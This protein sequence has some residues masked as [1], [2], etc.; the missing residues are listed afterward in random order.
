MK[1][2]RE[3]A[4]PFKKST[5]LFTIVGGAVL[6]NP[7]F[8]ADNAST[9]A[10]DNGD[11]EEIVITGIKA[12][13]KASMETK[14]DAVGVVDAINS[15]DIGK[16]PDTNLSEALQRVTGI[17]IDRRNG[18]GA[19]VTARGFGPQYNM[20]TLNGRE[21]PGA[22]GFGSG[23]FITGGQGNGSRSFNFAN[24]AAESISAVE[25]YKTSRADISPGGM[26]ATINIKTA[27]PF[28]NNGIVAN[29]GVKALHD[30]TRN[31]AGHSVTPE[32]SGIFSYTDDAKVWGIGLTGSYSKRDSGTNE[33]TVNDWHIQAWDGSAPTGGA[34]V[35]SVNQ[36]AGPFAPNAVVTN[37]PHD[38]QLYGIPNDI[39]YAFS[40]LTR[41]RTN[42][43]L[44]VQVAP[45]EG[46]T[47]T[48]D[49]TY[50]N[51]KLTED[52]SEQTEWM[53][54]NGFTAVT[55]D[56]NEAVATPV[57]LDEL[58]GSGKD[59]GYEQQH[60]QQKNTLG[61][62][63]FNAEWKVNDTFKIGF[64]YND[65]TAKSL[66]DDPLTGM[67]QLAVSVAG[68][69]PSSCL[70]FDNST[71]PKCTDQSNFWRQTFEFNN[72]LPIAMRTL[73]P[74][75]TA[76]VANTGGNSAYVFDG[77][78]LGTQVLRSSYTGQTTDVKQARLDGE[79]NFSDKGKFQFGVESK[80]VEMH[81]QN[82]GGYMALGDWG[83][84]DV[85][86]VPGMVALLKT[87][88]IAGNFNKYSAPGAPTVAYYGNADQLG[89]WAIT[90][91]AQGGGGYGVWAEGAPANGTL[92]FN[93]NFS[94]DA[95]VKETSSS[96]Y[97]QF[98]MQG[99]LGGL[100]ASVVAG[101]RYEKTNVNSTTLQ[102]VPT[103]LL[104][105]DDND[106]SI[107]RS[108]N[109]T[110]V[111]GDGHYNNLLPN[112]NFDLHFSDQ[113]IGRFAYSKTI[114]R[115]NYGNLEAGATVNGPGGSTLNGF[116]ATA[117]QN[118]PGLLPL[119]SDNFDLSLE[120]YFSD[121]GYI[122]AG[123]F[124]KRVNNF[125]GTA[126]FDQSLFG[127]QDQTGGPEAQKVFNW[128]KANNFATD[129]S[130]LFTAMAMDMNPGT[131]TD[132]NG[133]WTG[134]L[135]NYN[136][137]NAQHIA[138]ATKYDAVPTNVASYVSGSSTVT[139]TS[140]SGAGTDPNYIFAVQTPVNNK[141][142]RIHGFELG[143]QMFFGETG[144]GLQANYTIVRGDVHFDDT[145]DPNVNQFAL[146]GLSD[147]ANVVAMYE[148]YGLNARLA[149]NWRDRYLVNVNQ[150]GFRNPVYADP[151]KQIDLSVGYDF[152]KHFSVSF[153]GINLTGEGVRYYG[154]S[155]KQLWRLE[156]SGPRYELGVRYKL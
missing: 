120:Y 95:R 80:S 4:L 60:N 53:Q 12:S 108:A 10:S 93:P 77:T 84:G 115:A 146:L 153:D 75:Q 11:L 25:V 13:L 66:P 81:Q 76:A 86:Q 129:D 54:R 34:T 49:Y 143:G 87:Y 98:T 44:T 5:Y 64:D 118:D 48:A 117:N 99:E 119:E 35:N 140:V 6:L 83:V 122:S 133:T 155:E 68:K 135:A 131:F 17:S 23:D 73:Y 92:R 62:F 121:T 94:T 136:G 18:E 28:D 14:K 141:A 45:V 19:T 65:A 27:R 15:E 57:F 105:K 47:L 149:W 1:T 55:F 156:S 137:T 29:I 78:S 150:G 132:A 20:V 154:R 82:S 69:V 42:A 24:L 37:A 97:F 71:P 107:N 103:S 43:Q 85:G 130:S 148:K 50:A 116:Q 111:T 51:S 151:H 134:G 110:P 56:T 63:G 46:L 7:A 38:G 147:S 144:F 30:S 31:V 127:I 128:L 125:I 114:A 152:N 22:D 16:F 100:P 96:V 142:A 3:K 104:W 88:N 74:D 32:V 59:F 33:A 21:M 41:E 123:F 39:R 102:L 72:G 126:V 145:G 40:D 124:E 26:G 2:K 58:T 112:L 113:V 61:A 91:T 36:G 90:P 101:A 109:V 138:F 70:A 9:G 52:R 139:S 106:F 8:A 89:L 79:F 67:S